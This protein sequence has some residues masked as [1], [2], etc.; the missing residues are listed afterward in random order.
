MEKAK[1]LPPANLLAAL[2]A[3]DRDTLYV[4]SD[5]YEERGDRLAMGLRWLIRRGRLPHEETWAWWSATDKNGKVWNEPPC[6]CNLPYLVFRQLEPSDRVV[7]RTCSSPSA[8]YL[9]AAEAAAAA[10]P[11]CCGELWEQREFCS[12]CGAK[13]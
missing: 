1:P 9:D 6:A 11:V 3:G 4:L 7:G 2:D 12:D 8:A 10:L 13:I 5:W